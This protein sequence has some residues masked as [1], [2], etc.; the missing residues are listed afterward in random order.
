MRIVL[1]LSYF[2]QIGDPR[3]PYGYAHGAL[4]R[5]RRPTVTLSYSRPRRKNWFVLWR[6]AQMHLSRRIS[7]VLTTLMLITADCLCNS[8]VNAETKSPSSRSTTTDHKT[9]SHVVEDHHQRNS[10][11]TNLFPESRRQTGMVDSTS[12]NKVICGRKIS[13]NSTATR[14]SRHTLKPARYWLIMSPGARQLTA[15]MRTNTRHQPVSEIRRRR[16]LIDNARKL[17][18]RKV[19]WSISQD[20]VRGK[21]R[22]RPPLGTEQLPSEDNIQQMIDNSSDPEV[23]VT[24]LN[25][26]KVNKDFLQK[27]F[28]GKRHRPL[29]LRA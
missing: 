1:T 7:S 25:K 16:S 24:P 20:G 29:W 18:Q 8:S 28:V 5:A 17:K 23:A 22:R 15:Q 13:R 10:P 6:I 2:M 4:V 21:T 9:Y 19:A 27:Y 14:Q 3:S 26:V 11:T 12:M